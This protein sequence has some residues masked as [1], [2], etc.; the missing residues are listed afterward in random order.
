MSIVDDATATMIANFPARTGKPLDEWV[1]LVRASGRTKHGEIMTMLKTEH[2]MSHGFA[3]FVAL[4]ALK[5]DDLATSDELVEA[6]YVG[7]KATLRPLHDAAVDAARAFG[8][9]VE[10]APKKAYVSLRRKKQFGTVG[11]GPGGRLEIGLNLRDVEPAGRL[12][13]TTGMCTHRVRIASRDELDGELLGWLR[14][15]YEGA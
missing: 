9:D 6:M 3:N 11:P 7:S 12:E 4:T 10:V 1:A 5:R 2:G 13:A 15:A 8:A 14:Q